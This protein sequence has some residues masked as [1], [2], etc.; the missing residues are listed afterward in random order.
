MALFLDE[1]EFECLLDFACE[2]PIVVRDNVGM[3]VKKGRP[4]DEVRT[5]HFD[6]IDSKHF[7]C[8]YCSK[9]Y[10]SPVSVALRAHISN[11]S[12]AKKYKT[13][14]CSKVSEEVRQDMINSLDAKGSIVM[15]RKRKSTDDGHTKSSVTTVTTKYPT[16][17]NNC[18]LEFFRQHNIPE[19]AIH[20]RAF[21]NMCHRI[22]MLQAREHKLFHRMISEDSQSDSFECDSSMAV[23]DK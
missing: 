12:Y 14:L 21:E 20:S 6:R 16:R 3:V 13:T 5:V 4:Q 9:T 19:D 2:I 10:H 17:L 15:N 1:F 18:V 23:K 11:S 8:K 22:I 7:K